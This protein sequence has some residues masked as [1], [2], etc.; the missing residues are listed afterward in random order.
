M[1]DGKDERITRRV[2]MLKVAAGIVGLAGVG[3]TAVPFVK[4][5][6]PS[7]DILAAG[8]MTVDISGLKRGGLMTVIWR[9]QPVFILRRT[10]GMIKATEQTDPASL[11]DPAAPAQR[12]VTPELFVSMGI[13][14]H[15]G[16]LPAFKERLEGFG[17][18]GFYCPCHGGK[19]DTLGRRLAGPPPE[20]LHLVPYRLKSPGKLDIGTSEF[21]GYGADVRVISKLPRIGADG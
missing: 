3:F 2:F 15:L 16:C 5:M 17:Q 8:R 12:S 20:N 18:P 4:S 19:Y 7:K 10:A 13:C 9:K 11:L 1:T 14:T 6:E 21:S